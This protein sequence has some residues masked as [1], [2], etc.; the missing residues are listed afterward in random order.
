MFRA[1][2][3]RNDQ[4]THT[5]LRSYALRRFAEENVVS[6][7]HGSNLFSAF[8]VRAKRKMEDEKEPALTQAVAL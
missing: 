3:V 6:A 4:N 5:L 7:N 8:A 2:C 1:M